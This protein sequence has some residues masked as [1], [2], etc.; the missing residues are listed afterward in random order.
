MARQ[1]MIGPRGSTAAKARVA[2]A[3]A[4]SLEPAAL[5]PPALPLVVLLVE[6]DERLAE[7][8]TEYL[9]KHHIATHCETRGDRA[10]ARMQA[11][12]PDLIILDL[13]LPGRNGFS[14]CTELRAARPDTPII[15]LTARDEDSDRVTGLELGADNYLNKPI[16]PH[17]LLAHIRALMRRVDARHTASPAQRLTFGRLV[18]DFASRTVTMAGRPVDLS[19]S[20]FDLLWLLAQQ[21]GTVLS[22]D[23]L[24][25]QVRNLEYDG[26]N[27]SIDYRV[28]RLRRKLGAEGIAAER[29]KTVRGAGY[30]F[31]RADW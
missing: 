18:I 6:D 11:L 3:H 29:I 16:E 4:S 24:L 31:A 26:L 10:L 30:L 9:G 12:K 27:R 21:A 23:E 8:I 19:S 17:V 2:S 7:L 28:F 25:Q 13:M 14:V 22:R 5:T 1:S 15:M 20:E